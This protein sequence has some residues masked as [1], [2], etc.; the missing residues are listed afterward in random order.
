V[1]LNSVSSATNFNPHHRPET[2]PPRSCLF[3][4]LCAPR[5]RFAFTPSLHRSIRIYDNA[6]TG[7]EARR[8]TVPDFRRPTKPVTDPTISLLSAFQK[9]LSIGSQAPEFIQPESPPAM[10][11]YIFVEGGLRDLSIHAHHRFAG[12]SRARAKEPH[13]FTSGTITDR[14]SS[15]AVRRPELRRKLDLAC[16]FSISSAMKSSAS[17]PFTGLHFFDGP[18]PP[19]WPK[20]V[21]GS[22]R[23]AHLQPPR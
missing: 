13:V 9:P 4:K 19:R 16:R 2:T 12:H 21:L 11:Y 20:T 3:Q 23:A 7:R 8:N 1:G 18:R 22:W 5:K 6:L 10:K 14:L 17:T 15:S